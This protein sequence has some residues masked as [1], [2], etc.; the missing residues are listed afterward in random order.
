MLCSAISSSHGLLVGNC[1][2][3]LLLQRFDHPAG[4]S[5]F[6]SFSTLLLHPPP[7]VG[8]LHPLRWQSFAQRRV[9]LPVVPNI[10]I[11]LNRDGS[12]FTI[13]LRQGLTRQAT[14]KSKPLA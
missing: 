1:V 2:L 10:Q 6:V 11:V 12:D 5:V 4:Q 13:G 3:T 8:V 14:S 9:K 7:V